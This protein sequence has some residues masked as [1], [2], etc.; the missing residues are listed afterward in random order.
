MKAKWFWNTDLEF[1]KKNIPKKPLFRGLKRSGSILITPVVC[2][3]RAVL[4]SSFVNHKMTLI[5]VFSSSK[6]NLEEK[7][8]LYFLEIVLKDLCMVGTYGFDSSAYAYFTLYTLYYIKTR[9]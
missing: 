6:H 2:S 9:D 3:H 8:E 1:G 7:L 4:T 5:S